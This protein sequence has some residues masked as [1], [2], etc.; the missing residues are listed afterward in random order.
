MLRKIALMITLAT[1]VSAS[2]TKGQSY[3]Q[4]PSEIV[5]ANTS[6]KSCEDGNCFRGSKCFTKDGPIP[7]CV[8]KVSENIKRFCKKF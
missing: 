3:Q 6:E 4:W 7:K 2:S 8:E 1:L 5:N